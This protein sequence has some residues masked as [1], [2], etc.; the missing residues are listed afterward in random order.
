MADIDKTPEQDE[1]D[2]SADVNS[3]MEIGA[4]VDNNFH[5]FSEWRKD[6]FLTYNRDNR[7]PIED[8]ITMRRSNGQAREI[9]NLVFLPIWL[10]LFTGKWVAPSEGGDAEEEVEFANLMWTLPPA[11]GGMTTSR[12][13]LIN[14]IGLSIYDGFA[15]FELV[16]HIPKEGPLKGKKTLR[17]MAYR[18]PRTVTLLQDEKGG[19]AGFRQVASLGGKKID[20]TLSPQKTAL[21]TVNGHENPLYGV[22]FFETAYFHYEATLKWYYIAQQAGQI[23]AVPGR[24]GTVPRH[25]RKEDVAAFIR[26]LDNYFFNTSMV[27]KEGYDVRPFPSTPGFNF[28]EHINH[29]NLMMAKSV[30]A[31]FIENHQRTVLVEN[32]T[33]DASAD[34][35]LLSMEALTTNLSEVLT[36]HVMPKYIKMNFPGSTKYPVFKPGPLSDAAKKK[37]SDVWNRVLVSGI[38]NSTP[39]YVRELEKKSV[40]D[41]G[42]DVD[43]EEI[44]RREEEAAAAQAAQA[45]A[46]AQQSQMESIE[47]QR[48]EAG[49]IPNDPLPQ[50][51][52]HDDGSLPQDSDEAA[53]AD[54]EYDVE[55][56]VELAKRAFHS[57][58]VDHKVDEGVVRYE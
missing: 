25:S 41:L 26:S 2:Y 1:E 4:Q 10:S 11:L 47:Q 17:K 33:E 14:Q 57:D 38:L 55:D 46:L 51:G 18:D 42:L 56:I 36:N 43:F 32:S 30:L 40:E 16:T 3:V 7:V 35:F 23:S 53:M 28:L 9:G 31:A 6:A 27:M 19:Y 21:F 29:H 49:G 24:I 15:P 12:S 37:I 13:Q 22:S 48:A 39:E 8:L 50:S 20:V 44:S 34:L 58:Y 52:P 45:E 5:S 54:D